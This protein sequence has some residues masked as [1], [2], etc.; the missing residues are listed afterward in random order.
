MSLCARITFSIFVTGLV[1]EKLAIAQQCNGPRQLPIHDMMLQGHTYKTLYAR[2]GHAECLFICR[3]ETL[4]QS[5][6]FVKNQSICKFN[7]RTKEASPENFVANNERYYVKLD[8]SR[9]PLGSIRELPAKSCKEIKDNEDGNVNNGNFWFYSLI[10]GTIVRALCD[11]DNEDINECDSNIHGCS[12][13]ANCT[14]TVGS[15]L[16]KC[17]SNYRGD[18]RNCIDTRGFSQS[19]IL[20]SRSISYTNSLISLLNPVLQSSA[21]SRFTRCWHAPSQGWSPSDFHNLCDGKGPTVTIIRVGSY[22]FGGYTDKSWGANNGYTRSTKSFLYSLHNYYGYHNRKFAIW[23][24]SYYPNAIYDHEN[25]GPIFGAGH[26]LYTRSTSGHSYCGYTYQLP[27]G[28]SY[29]SSCTFYTGSYSFTLSEIEV[30]YEE[31][32]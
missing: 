24:A 11:M 2:S 23:S 5:F 22:M 26:D 6:N 8:V 12:T 32:H 30:F 7:N 18:G 28:A 20:R 25:Y 3:K 13:N 15:Y 9:V 14:N 10:P 1:F 16:C 27:P 29:G 31:W 4:C 17:H 21:R 19:S